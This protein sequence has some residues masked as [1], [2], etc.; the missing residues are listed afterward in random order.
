MTTTVDTTLDLADALAPVYA[1]MDLHE[2][3]LA[4]ARAA[5]KQLTSTKMVLHSESA[6]K[7]ERELAFQRGLIAAHQAALEALRGAVENLKAQCH[8]PSSIG[9]LRL[10]V[11]RPAAKADR[12]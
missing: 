3:E 8:I 7:A 5:E 10:P 1:A 11:V 12:I 9:A 6:L 4:Q 2:T